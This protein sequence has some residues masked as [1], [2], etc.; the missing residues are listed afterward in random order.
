M[1]S[2]W[3]PEWDDE[4]D[5]FGADDQMDAETGAR[6]SEVAAYL[7]ATPAPAL[8]DAYAARISAA[9]AAEAAD[10]A[11]SPAADTSPPADTSPAAGHSL[12]GRDRH[13]GRARLR[14]GLRSGPMLLT[15]SALAF[16]VL[17]AFGFL[18]S[19]GASSSSSSSSAAAS[20]ALG[21]ASAAPSRSAFGANEAGPA[22]R[23][24]STAG[25][26][27]LVT[28][29]GTAYRK[30]TLAAQVRANLTGNKASAGPVPAA[31]PTAGASSGAPSETPAVTAGT[32]TTQLRGCVL[33][34]TGGATPGLV[35][36]ATYQGEAAYIIA[37]SGHVWVVGLG[38]TTVNQELIVS[39][40]LAG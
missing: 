5:L 38:C 29:S 18:L 31:E 37:T 11:S 14:R 16:V 24:S 4:E 20:S 27:F 7:A 10:R 13:R 19:H 17:I 3:P 23:P 34:L 35:D 32:P 28:E 8:P 2:D 36:Q 9:I 26:A 1:S 15:G 21:V 39:A 12:T 22:S 33:Q 30:A 6:L 25:T 40:S